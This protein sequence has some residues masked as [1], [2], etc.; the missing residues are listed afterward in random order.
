MFPEANAHTCA[1]LRIHALGDGRK[2]KILKTAGD[3]KY[4]A[5]RAE[6]SIHGAVPR[7]HFFDKLSTD[8][9]PHGANRRDDVAGYGAESVE[10]RRALEGSGYVMSQSLYVIVRHSLFAVRKRLELG[11]KLFDLVAFHFQP[12]VFETLLDDINAAM[13]AQ[14]SEM[15]SYEDGGN[16]WMVVVLLMLSL[17]ISAFN[18]WRKLRKKTRDNY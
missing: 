17:V 5:Y 6:G 12:E 2:L 16:G 4:L 14:W 8:F 3:T 7:R 15:K 11:E 10:L 18:I 1:A 9:Q 13:D